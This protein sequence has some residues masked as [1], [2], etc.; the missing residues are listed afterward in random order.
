MVSG[1]LKYPPPS[2]CWAEICKCL[3]LLLCTSTS[4]GHVHVQGALDARVSGAITTACEILSL[5]AAI[6]TVLINVGVN[7]SALL[8]PAGIALAFA[9]RDMTQNFLAGASRRLSTCSSKLRHNE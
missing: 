3:G 8:L 6:L 5:I 2:L 1:G 9:A 4:L 7:V